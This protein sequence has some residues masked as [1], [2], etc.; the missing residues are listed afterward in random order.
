MLAASSFDATAVALLLAGSVVLLVFAVVFAMRFATSFPALPAPGPETSDLG[1]EPPAVANLLV[2]RCHP[3]RA[4]A[5]ATVVDL[6]ARGLLDLFEAGPEHFVVQLR[7]APHS[8]LTPYEHQVLELVAE[9]AVGGSA[10]LEA[11]QL[12][13]D[14]ADAWHR[15]FA[16]HVVDDARSRG[17]L[18]GRWSAADWRIFAGLAGLGFALVA[19]GLFAARVEDVHPASGGQP[20]HRADWFWVALGAWAVILVGIRALRA[21]RYSPA[22]L[23]AASR[24]LGV[25]D[26]L[27]HDSSFAD[28]PPAAVAIWDRLLAYGT[29]LGAAHGVATGIPLGADDPHTAWSRQGGDWH[30]VHVEYPHH[31]G[32]GQSPRSVALGGLARTLF[33]GAL[34]F[35]VLPAI[36]HGVWTLGSDATRNSQ[37]G[38]RTMLT[39]V[40]VFS[41]AFTILGGFL[42]LRLGDG[43]VRLWRGLADLGSTTTL[44]GLVVKSTSSGSWFAVDPGGVEDVKALHPAELSLPRSGATVRV[45]LTPH[46]HHVDRIEVLPPSPGTAAAPM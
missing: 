32:Y 29:A 14:G 3:T 30:Q 22:G 9:K 23:A 19:S 4:A 24:W 44:E 40:G 28:A 25:R 8:G 36:A 37:L 10:P 11:I 41:V 43:L 18:R 34:T 33:W 42:L 21:V 12:D 15:R 1:E 35:A 16:E 5:A 26:F 39:L 27:R 38:D 45:T 13:A 31:F 17:L 2:R 46:L 6:A 20:F 7:T